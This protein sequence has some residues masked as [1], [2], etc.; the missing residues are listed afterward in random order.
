MVKFG[1]EEVHLL[2]PEFWDRVASPTRNMPKPVMYTLLSTR[3][4][5][6]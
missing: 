5:R 2:S 3:T 1:K 6:P 4:V